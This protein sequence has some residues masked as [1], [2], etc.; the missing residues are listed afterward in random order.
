D[1][2]QA[3]IQRPTTSSVHARTAVIWVSLLYAYLAD[4]ARRV[5]RPAQQPRHECRVT[6][7]ATGEPA[8]NG[9]PSTQAGDCRENNPGLSR[10]IALRQQSPG[11]KPQIGRAHV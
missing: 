7:P 10:T 6:L 2:V 8:G 11:K 5:D 3:S 9:E 4:N 1:D